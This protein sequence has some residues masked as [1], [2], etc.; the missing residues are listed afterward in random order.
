MLNKEQ[1]VQ[2]SD[3]TMFNSSKTAKYIDFIITFSDLQI[4]KLPRPIF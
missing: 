3:T 4:F 2:V 1:D